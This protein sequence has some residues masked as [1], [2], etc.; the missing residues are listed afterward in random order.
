MYIKNLNLEK[1]THVIT[2]RKTNQREK[3][4]NI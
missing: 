1:H 4:L 2:I 3:E